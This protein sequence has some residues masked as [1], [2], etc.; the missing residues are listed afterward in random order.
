ML[1]V[2][3]P[4]YNYNITKL[5]SDIHKQ[6]ISTNI[7]FEIICIDDGSNSEFNSENEKINTLKNSK[8]IIQSK[9][10]G[11]SGNRN[12]LALIAKYNNLLF[13]DG[14]SVIISKNFINNYINKI[15]RDTDII[16]GG[17]VHPKKKQQPK[18]QLRWKYGIQIEDKTAD[19]RKNNAYKTLMFNNTLINKK[20]FQAIKFDSSLTKY[21]H[22]DTLFA[23][24]AYLDNLSVLHIN[25]PVLHGDI[26]SNSVYINKT[27]KGI[28]N[29]LSLY[30]SKKI[31]AQFVKILIYFKKIEKFKL[32]FLIGKLFQLS[33]QLIKKQL[34]SSNPSL[35][36]F[37]FYK[38]SY[39]CYL[40][41]KGFTTNRF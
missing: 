37:N 25:N 34:K 27:E 15:S 31:D 40:D 38:L 5:V 39:M 41:L 32:K 28:D 11:L 8:F 21:G 9:N 18:K 17:R 7:D 13:I 2:L 12:N 36:L 22:E 4:V 20:R 10:T 24:Q 3:I 14:D 19:I 6:L 16:Y 1:S 30:N 23:Y 35:F 33:Q 26:D 29:L